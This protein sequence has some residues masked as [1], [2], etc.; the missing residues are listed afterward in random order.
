MA[1]H[2]GPK[3]VKTGMLLAMDGADNRF[4]GQNANILAVWPFRV[5]TGS[6][7]GYGQNGDG[8]SRLLDSN[9]FGVTDIVWDVSNQD[10]TSD[11]D[12]GWN[13]ST[14]D[15]DNTKMYRFSVWV[16]RKNIGNGSFYLGT[17]G[18]N[19]AGSNIGVYNRSNGAN[20]TNPYF[21]SSGWWGSVNTWY[22]VVG[23]IWPAGSGTGA[24]HPESGIYDVNG[25]YVTSVG[26]FVWRP[27]NA[28]STHR[29]YLYYSTNTAT[30]QQW[31][32]PRVE[33][34]DTPSITSP[35]LS[36]LFRNVGGRW[37]LAKKVAETKLS[38][39]KVYLNTTNKSFVFG[40]SDADKTISV[41]LSGNFNKLEGTIACWIK[42]YSYSGSNGLFVNRT[43][44]T[45]NAI[46]W[47]WIGTWSSGSLFYLRLGNGST[48]CSNDLTISSWSTNHAPVNQWTHVAVT[49]KSAGTAK[50]YVNGNV[51]TS[52][53]ISSIPNT[54]PS[55]EGRI[56]LGHGSGSTG[57]W[58]GEIAKFNI[59]NIQMSD[60]EV[61]QNFNAM[62][63]RFG[64]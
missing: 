33:I 15:I 59:Y 41:P 11:A 38:L 20:N 44:T 16:R 57:S 64:K 47:F 63:G 48:C 6:E 54:N 3:I 43:D 26:D 27:D 37:N 55:T 61:R 2:G 58:D 22:L 23:H 46:D 34:V 25:N 24:V 51:V 50:I 56:G 60:S 7:T 42:P 12:G 53:T 40:G 14:F 49:W 1:A 18:R 9:P 45:A 8:N 32:D 35:A 31:W 36:R 5:G 52:R 28:K 17:Y 30:N 62:R 39:R 19:S 10:A 29:S 13:S 4:T 21:R